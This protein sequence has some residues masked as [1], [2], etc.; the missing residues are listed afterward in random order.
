[1]AER[2]LSIPVPDLGLD[3]DSGPEAIAARKAPVL[4]NFLTDRPGTIV[5]RG[6]LRGFLEYQDS[7]AL[8]PPVGFP[9]YNDNILIGRASDT[10]GYHPWVAPYKRPNSETLLAPADE[11]LKHV[12][13]STGVVTDVTTTDQRTVPGQSWTRLG[14]PVYF[15][16]YA[17]E[18]G[19]SVSVNGGYQWLTYLCRWDG[20]TAEPT[21]YTNAPRGAQAVK[22]HHRRLFVLGGRNPDGSGSI[23]GNTLWYSDPTD[24]S[25]LTDALTSWQ[26]DASGLVNQIVL[27]ADDNDFG[28]ALAQLGGNLVIL[29][30]QSIWVLYGYSPSTFLVKPVVTELGC[31]DPRSVVE[32]EEGVY[33]MSQ[34]GFVRFDGAGVEVVSQGL[35]TTMSMTAQLVVGGTGSAGGYVTATA[36]GDGYIG[37]VASGWTPGS[38]PDPDALDHSLIYDTK[39]GAWVTITSDALQ[40]GG[41][42]GYVRTATQTVTY[43]RNLLFDATY[44]TLPELLAPAE[45][46]ADTIPEFFHWVGTPEFSGTSDTLID[47][48]GVEMFP[49]TETEYLIPARWRTTLI[50]LTGPLRRAQINRTI[51]DYAWQVSED[52]G[53]ADQA[54]EVELSP[55][56]NDNFAAVTY[57]FDEQN[58]TEAFPAD[59]GVVIPSEQRRVR[60]VRDGFFEASDVVVE[61]RATGALT[62]D[63]PGYADVQGVHLLVQESHTR[64]SSLP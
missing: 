11:T 4:E 53:N 60:G 46:G 57:I 6:P 31:L 10:A 21:E 48:E 51:L 49:G 18:P 25:A 15:I 24:D 38:F 12:N 16:G 22:A 27:L 32:S 36:I 63:K 28:V 45:R 43:D 37:L 20:T 56:Y 50:A 29:R 64:R 26:D 2:L 14:E 39:S 9:V 5:M 54:W 52:S 23:S 47:G 58:R 17:A 42:L 55:A 35:R 1:M 30:R 33:F 61:V 40:G 7:E 8:T 44:M 19:E 13:L 3:Q 59:Q 34:Q 62:K 41:P